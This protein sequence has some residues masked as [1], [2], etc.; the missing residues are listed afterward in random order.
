MVQACSMHRPK[1]LAATDGRRTMRRVDDQ[2]TTGRRFGPDFVTN[3]SGKVVWAA[4]GRNQDTLRA[5]V[6]R[7]AAAEP[8]LHREAKSSHQ[9]GSTSL[10]IVRTAPRLYSQFRPE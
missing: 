6:G 9:A 7:G 2:R 4:E 3:Y 5:L 1:S 8:K 10:S